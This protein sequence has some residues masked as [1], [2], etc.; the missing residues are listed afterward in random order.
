MKT[1]VT[2]GAGYIGSHTVAELRRRGAAVV[3]ID[4]LSAGHREALPSDVPLLI[5]DVGDRERVGRF[6]AEHDVSSIVHFAAKIQVGESVTDPRKYWNGNVVATS[7]LLDVAL[8]RGVKQFIL[9]STAAVY[10]TPREVPILEEHAT[11]P[12][13]PY[14][15]SKLV[16]ERILASYERAYGLKYACLRY[17]N[18]A[19]ADPEAGLG[20]RH[21]PETHLIPIILE[22]ALGKRPNVTVFGR[23]YPTPDGTCIRDYI[24]VRDLADAHVAA[25]EHLVRG[26]ESGAFNLGTGHGYSVAEVLEVARRV[27]GR[28]IPVEY[29]P[30]RAGDPPSL[31]ASAE[32]ASRILGFRAQRS[33]L[34]QIVRDAWSF[35]TRAAARAA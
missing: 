34:E 20:E 18:A 21:D 27:T 23:D 15:E 4:D 10:G 11:A 32:R 5:S 24:H 2:G 31:V 3:V 12:I 14:G 19:G 29:G 26:G 22:A 6:L 7:A 13:N 9:S 30:R 33:S 16:I 17:F 25:L 28:A 35:H 8:D 1:L